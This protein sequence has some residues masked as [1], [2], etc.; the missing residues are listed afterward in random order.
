MAI[1]MSD[2]SDIELTS[3]EDWAHM[4]SESI[5]LTDTLKDFDREKAMK[6]WFKWAYPE[7]NHER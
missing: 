1:G 4:S 3:A 7:V 2:Y 5:S 6:D